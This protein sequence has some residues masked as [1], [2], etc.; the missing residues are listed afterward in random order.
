M[1]FKRGMNY[2]MDYE[3]VLEDA[4]QYA[5]E[6]G[7]YLLK[8]FYEDFKIDLKGSKDLVTEVDYACEKLIIE[9]IKKTY[10]N[11]NI[12][13]EESGKHETDSEYTWIIDPLDGT[14]NFTRGIPIFGVILSFE[15][16]GETII[17]VHHL[18]AIN[19][20]YYALKGKG[21]FL[22]D[23]PISVSNNDNLSNFIIGTGDFNIGK[24]NSERDLDNKL[25]STITSSLSP[26]TM[27]T[28]ILGAACA[29]LAFVASGKLDVLFYAFSNPWDVKAGILLIEEAGGKVFQIG[30]L[31][32]FS[33]GQNLDEI[34]SVF[35]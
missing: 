28:K 6:A 15:K 23:K 33:N 2:F 10:K 19:Q 32:I 16:N 13:A 29:D 34:K 24:N 22:N 12:I 14:I 35:I 25:L 3:K 17:G 18:P 11:H 27:R 21:A 4:I 30:D 1:L 20:T 5:K 31:T 8:Q 9:N 7:E 26:M